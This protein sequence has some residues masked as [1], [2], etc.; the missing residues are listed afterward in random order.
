MIKKKTHQYSATLLRWSRGLKHVDTLIQNK[1]TVYTC[2]VQQ[3]RK[4]LNITSISQF[5]RTL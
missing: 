1:S 5:Q 4:T 2:G 3:K